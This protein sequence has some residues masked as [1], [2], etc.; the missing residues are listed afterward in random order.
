MRVG[1]IFN[2]AAGG[3][4]RGPGEKVQRH[5]E[6]AGLTVEAAPTRSPGEATLLARKLADRVDV[7]VAA[8][9]DGTVNEVING[10]AGSGVSLGLVPMGTVN[11]L[12][13]EL[14]IP[15]DPV[16]AA[17][18]VARGVTHTMDLGFARQPETGDSRYFVLMAGVGIDALTIRELDIGLK[19]RFRRAAFV[20]T[21][22]RAFFRHRSPLL[23]VEIGGQR[24]EAHLVVAGNCRYYG[25]RFGITTRAVPTDGLLD[26]LVFAGRGFLRNAVFWLGVPFG[27]H[28]RHPGTSYVR[29]SSVSVRA[30]DA[31]DQVWFHTDGELAGRLPVDME[32]R[33]NALR[34]VVPEE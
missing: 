25:G 19:S 18:V 34:V 29:G 30:D 1:L 15:L 6:E 24:Y 26:V 20:W 16:R 22:V 14:G 5:L 4:R 13:L 33:E 8:G 9:G 21:G 2:P 31:E 7:V 28:L 32:I 12:A 23:Q 11:V 3:G 10:L 17:E 27:L